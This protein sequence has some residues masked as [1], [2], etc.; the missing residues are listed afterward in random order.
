MRPALKII[1]VVLVLLVVVLYVVPYFAPQN[2]SWNITYISMDITSGRL[3]HERY[4]FGIKIGDRVE[5]TRLSRAYRRLIAEPGEPEWR[6]VE[7]ECHYVMINYVFQGALTG[8]QTL[9]NLLQTGHLS[10]DAERQAVSTFLALMQKDE[11]A[12]RAQ[13]YAWSLTEFVNRV[14]AA[15]YHITPVEASQLPKPPDRK[16]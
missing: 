13:E 16:E 5:E 9:T 12:S 6:R 8:A 4:L 10:E 15:P 3:R 7:A 2:W 1:A 14:A 11:D